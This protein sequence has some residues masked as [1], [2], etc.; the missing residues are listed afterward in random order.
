MV[1]WSGNLLQPVAKQLHE[2]ILN[3]FDFDYLYDFVFNPEKVKGRP[4]KPRR[5]PT[6]TEPT[7]MAEPSDAMKAAASDTSVH[8]FEDFSK[9]P[10]GQRP[11]AW[12]TGTAGLVTKLD[13]LPGNW[14]VMGG[15]HILLTPKE[16]TKPLPQNFTVSY[17]LVAAQKF[18][19]GAKGLTFQLASEKS[20]GSADWYISLNLRPGF[21]GRDGEV[22]IVTK[23]PTGYA[24]GGKW[25]PAVGFSNNKAQNR[26]RVS[27]KKTGE[28]IEVFID[29][30]RIAEYQKAVP[31]DLRFNAMSFR[32]GDN[33]G[34]NDKFYV[35]KITIRKE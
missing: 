4:Y 21:D 33:P 8:F 27:I 3:N 23:F 29:D 22:T 12:A 10:P 20:A 25:M 32:T 13:G 26:I 35:S 9:T 11:I 16:L 31:A 1:T 24:S 7:L 19:W 14:A 5:S 18:T 34:E 15:D 30:S 28:T 17:E 2:A 6:A